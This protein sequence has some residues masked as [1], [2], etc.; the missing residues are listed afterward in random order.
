[1]LPNFLHCFVTA[2]TNGTKLPT[3]CMLWCSHLTLKALPCKHFGNIMLEKWSS[4]EIVKTTYFTAHFTWYKGQRN[5]SMQYLVIVWRVFFSRQFRMVARSTAWSR[6]A[7]PKQ[8]RTESL[9]PKIPIGFFPKSLFTLVVLCSYSTPKSWQSA[10]KLFCPIFFSVVEFICG[11]V[12]CG[13]DNY[14]S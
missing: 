5:Y 14:N 11:N 13:C 12:K 8:L 9:S 3:K 1:M 10:E 6:G 2:V 7:F 4:N